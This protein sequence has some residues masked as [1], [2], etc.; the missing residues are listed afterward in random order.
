MLSVPLSREIRRPRDR[1][2]RSTMS[3]DTPQ[4]SLSC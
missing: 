2:K 3:N 1:Q 4:V